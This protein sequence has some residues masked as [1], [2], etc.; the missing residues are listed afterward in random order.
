MGFPTKRGKVMNNK[1]VKAFDEYVNGFDLSDKRIQNKVPHSKRVADIA[2]EIGASIFNNK[3]IIELCY[4]IGLLHDVGRFPQWTKF[5]TF[6][7]FRSVDHADESIEM[8]FGDTK[9]IKAFEVPEKWHKYIEMAVKYHN[10]LKIDVTVLHEAVKDY[11]LDYVLMLT[12][13]KIARDADKLDIFKI[14]IKRTAQEIETSS[15]Y[16]GNGYT[17]EIME[18][19]WEKRTCD[20]SFNKTL[21]DRAVGILA[22]PYDLNFETSRSMFKIMAKDYAG[23]I[24]TNYGALLSEDDRATLTECAKA[25]MKDFSL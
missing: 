7:D 14:F 21:L 6:N 15:E 11:N 5:K 18:A 1:N 17:P 12:L 19:F 8:L 10:K 24:V 13:C 16:T 9:L 4:T 23:A 3:E 25:L 2:E 22:L 20:F